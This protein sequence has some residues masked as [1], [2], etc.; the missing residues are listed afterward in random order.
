MGDSG[1]STQFCLVST[2]GTALPSLFRAPRGD[3]S[4]FSARWIVLVPKLLFD[5]PPT[6]LLRIGGVKRRHRQRT[7]AV[8]PP[9]VSAI[10]ILHS[11]FH[12]SRLAHVDEVIVVAS[13]AVDRVDT[14]TV[15][16]AVRVGI[17]TLEGVSAD[18]DAHGFTVMS[19]TSGNSTCAGFSM[20]TTTTC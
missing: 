1:S 2:S 17:R 12:L 3:A 7:R 20:R 18:S 19:L 6:T 14:R 16:K 4:D 13:F 5:C 15:L 11:R 9:T 8:S 10:V